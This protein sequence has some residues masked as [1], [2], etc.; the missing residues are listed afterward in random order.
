M[1]IA[2]RLSTIRK[3]DQIIVMDQ[4]SVAERGTHEELLKLNDG[5]YS[6]LWNMQ[7]RSHAHDNIMSTDNSEDVSIAVESTIL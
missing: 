4:G 6:K 3:A 1:I 7:L 2:H 5:Y